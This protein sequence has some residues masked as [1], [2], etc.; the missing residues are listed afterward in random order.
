MVLAL[1][2]NEEQCM[3]VFLVAIFFCQI[4][5]GIH[6]M[7]REARERRQEASHV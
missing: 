3:V 2:S 1:F 5:F 6:C 4:V 7:M